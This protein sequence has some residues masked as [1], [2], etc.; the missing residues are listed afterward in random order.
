MSVYEF[1]CVLSQMKLEKWYEWFAGRGIPVAM[2]ED[3]SKR[4]E[5][6]FSVW[7]DSERLRS[8]PWPK[9]YR[10]VKSANGFTKEG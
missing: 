10:I 3:T 9:T 2:V 1:T 8:D 7:R 5:N 4:T 6:R